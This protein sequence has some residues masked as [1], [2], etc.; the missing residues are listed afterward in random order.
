MQEDSGR[1]VNLP[2]LQ[3]MSPNPNDEERS[4]Q[5]LPQQVHFPAAIQPLG[6]TL[7]NS[8]DPTEVGRGVEETRPRWAQRI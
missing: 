1:L 2:F 7:G 3:V 5:Q 8:Q 6:Q 4:N